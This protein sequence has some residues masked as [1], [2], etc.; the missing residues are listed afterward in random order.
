MSRF[1]AGRDFLADSCRGL[2]EKTLKIAKQPRGIT[3]ETKAIP[4]FRQQQEKWRRDAASLAFQVWMLTRLLK[5]P[6]VPWPARIAAGCAVGYLVSPIQLIPTFIPVIGQLDDLLI[7]YLGMKLVHKL[8]PAEIIAECQAQLRSSSFV[9]RAE[10]P[11]V[12]AA[13]CTEAVPLGQ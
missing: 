7:I 10:N 5:H 3:V 12:V 4:W 1:C 9:Q 8:A 13:N 11:G 6:L 2:K